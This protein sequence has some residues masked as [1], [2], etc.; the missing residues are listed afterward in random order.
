MMG[1]GGVVDLGNAG[2]E[3]PSVVAAEEHYYAMDRILTALPLGFATRWCEPGPMGCACLGCA[4]GPEAGAGN[5][6]QLG[7]TKLDWEYWK[8]RRFGS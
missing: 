5:L 1:I 4:N 6:S 8:K 7:F 3:D 2:F